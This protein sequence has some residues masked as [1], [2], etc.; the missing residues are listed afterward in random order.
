MRRLKRKPTR[1]CGCRFTENTE[2]LTR[3]LWLLG[4]LVVCAPDSPV[5]HVVQ[6]LQAGVQVQWRGQVRGSG[7]ADAEIAHHSLTVEH[8]GGAARIIRKA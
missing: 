7:Q 3:S 5:S 2:A 6:P 8:S 1:I 4:D